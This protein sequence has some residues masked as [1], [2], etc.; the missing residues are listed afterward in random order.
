MKLGLK[1]FDAPER[2]LKMKKLFASLAL[3]LSLCFGGAA[4]AQT[5]P[6]AEA[7]VEA[8][9]EVKADAA[10]PATAPAAAPAAAASPAA[11]PAAPAVSR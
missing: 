5:A 8:K 3:G 7:K 11:S 9:A 1:P 4:F 2:E 10:A 6:A